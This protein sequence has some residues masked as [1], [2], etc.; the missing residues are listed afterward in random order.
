M[1]RPPG[2]RDTRK[3]RN[4]RR[5]RRKDRPLLR[6]QRHEGSREGPQEGILRQGALRR[7][8]GKEP[9]H[10][11]A[12]CGRCDGRGEIGWANKKN[13]PSARPGRDLLGRL[14]NLFLYRFRQPTHPLSDSLIFVTRF[15]RINCIFLRKLIY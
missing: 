13:S 7:T 14:G 12:D 9:S 2:S 15:P 8:H 11:Q 10:A 4:R 6:R 3:R 1:H 5:L